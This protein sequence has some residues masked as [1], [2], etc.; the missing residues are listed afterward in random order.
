M[1]D[2]NKLKNFIEFLSN[3]VGF[4]FD[5]DDF[6][7]RIKLQKYVYIAKEFGWNH[8]YYYNIYI[9]GPYSSKLAKDYY[10]LTDVDPEPILSLAE[11]AFT[12]LVIKKD[13]SWLEV[14][15]TMLSL[16]KSYRNHY[17][18]RE[19]E[20]NVINRTM[21]LKSSIH[22]NIICDAYKELKSIGLL[23]TIGT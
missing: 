17:E 23:T 12:E 10:D 22:E 13:T 5:I 2:K 3:K 19:L 1:G 18:S 16:H 15:A 6:D 21:E 20:N 8:T 11:D 14:A 4:T 7:H 9:R